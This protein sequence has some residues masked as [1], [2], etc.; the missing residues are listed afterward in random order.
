M[1]DIVLMAVFIISGQREKCPP[2]RSVIA[3]VPQAIN[4]LR[5]LRATPTMFLFKT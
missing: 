5:V 4:C 3:R 2:P 1:C